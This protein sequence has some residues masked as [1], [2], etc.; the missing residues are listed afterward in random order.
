MSD[1]N[2]KRVESQQAKKITLVIGNP[3]YN[4]NQRNANDQNKNRHYEFIHQRI[5]NT[6]VARSTAQKTK[7]YDMYTHFWRWAM[8]KIGDEGIIAF[9]TNRSFIDARGFDGFRQEV[10]KNFHY[11]YIVDL[12]GD[13]RGQQ[14]PKGNV[15]GIMTGVAIMFLVK[16]KDPP[17]DNKGCAIRY[18][19]YPED[20]D[21][22][23][24]LRC[25]LTDEW[26]KMDHNP[27][28]PSPS[29]QWID[30]PHTDFHTLL[31]I[32]SKKAPQDA[33]FR[34]FALGFSTNRDA[35]AYD[36]DKK[37]LA[38]KA[39]YFAD[40]YNKEVER[41]KSATEDAYK[42]AYED[43]YKAAYEAA[44]KAAAEAAAT[45]AEAA[46][47]AAE[48]A[49]DAVKAM[50][51]G[52]FVDRTIKWSRDLELWLRRKRLMTYEKECIVPAM[53][54]P[55]VKKHCY[56]SHIIVDVPS[57][58][59]QFFGPHSQHS[60][61]CICVLLG[62]R[63]PFA[64]LATKHLTGLALF[65][66]PVRCFPLYTY[67]DDGQR[68]SNIP[69]ARLREFRDHYSDSSITPERIFAYTYAVLHASAYRERYAKDLRSHDPRL[70]FLEDFFELA[71]LGQRLLELHTGYEE[72][73]AYPLE[74]IDLPKKALS[75]HLKRVK[76]ENVIEID[77]STTL[78][79]VP[80]RAWDYTLGTRSALEW[81]LSQ[82]RELSPKQE[83]K[84]GLPTIE[85]VS[86]YAFA[87]HKEEVIE[88]LRK[89]CTVSVETM[90]L[91]A[92]IDGLAVFS[93][94]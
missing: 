73:D 94:H 51:T 26:K 27:I 29:H 4:A 78:R 28:T 66:E 37:R 64:V 30:I 15:F 1:E 79:G 21:A 7:M 56:Y 74:R 3:P 44:Y 68:S 65:V 57:K 8:D 83:S 62:M 34:L 93:E 75:P 58:H 50:S 16:L 41:W 36:F 20:Y 47:T 5:K 54:R 81:V 13:N 18:F 46:A 89:V 45:A 6:F 19:S 55:F 48:A 72:V 59:A 71:D 61:T 84:R 76:A 69:E 92:K 85:G 90:E 31:P 91:V 40:F 88:L 25:L 49:A 12:K 23:A 60:N 67:N 39:Q 70:P 24:K 32:C 43:A 80:E 9:I 87:N 77:T 53:Y 38:K 10:K 22:A 82:Y 52:P 11:A 33:L 63:I 2:V 35:W 17:S 86:S 42:A 14:H